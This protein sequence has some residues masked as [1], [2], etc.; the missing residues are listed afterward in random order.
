MKKQLAEVFR[1]YF[2]SQKKNAM[3]SKAAVAAWFL[4]FFVIMVG[5]LGGIFTAL[6]LSFCGVFT[7]AG[8]GWLYFLLMGGVAVVL[9][10]FGSVFN[11]YSSL[12]LAKD[13]DLLLSLP[14]PAGT[15]MAARLLNVYLLGTM[16]SSTVLVPTLV[17]YWIT[18]GA[19]PVR[20]ICGLLLIL[21]VTVIVLLF[22][23]LLGW[24]VAKL[25][26]RIRN[27]SVITVIVSLLFVGGY[28]YFYFKAN[29]LIQ[30]IIRHADAYGEKIKG[31]AYGLYLFGRIGEGDLPAAAIFMAVTAA[32][33]AL[34][35]VLMQRSFLQITTAGGNTKKARYTER[36][37]AQK[38]VFGALLAKEFSRFTSSANYMLNS[39]LGILLIPA[40]G[41]L[42]LFKGKVICH[43]LDVMLANRPGSAAVLIC[44]LLCTVSS[45]NDMAVPSVS[46]E[47]MSLWIPK[48]LPIRPQQVIRAKM[49]VHLILT[50]VPLLFTCICAAVIVPAS[51]AVKAMLCVLPLIYAVFSTMYGMTLGIRMPL[52]SW[53]TEIT[54]LKQSGAVN[55]FLFTSW[56]FGIALAGLYLLIGY[57]LG[58]AIYLGV[59]SVL[60][61][62][63]GIWLLRWLDTKGTAAFAA[64]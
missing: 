43:A 60:F 41:V 1:N 13:N 64:L 54:P 10:A 14:I 38:T 51:P 48:S 53:T 18:A 24:V 2:Y 37:V 6:S 25:S 19:T 31:A 40:C 49:S 62:V 33:F 44:T 22:S 59:C 58:A 29:N 5:M 7:Q 30:E 46:L 12:Y 35:W 15:I 28:Y 17:I 4:F 11:T 55:I 50:E 23:C 45:M 57:K 56:G 39:G 36:A 34:V 20:V 63:L 61:S 52:L 8:L 9:G 27:K 3:R 42:M 32:L 21:I 26:R 16:Y 47:G